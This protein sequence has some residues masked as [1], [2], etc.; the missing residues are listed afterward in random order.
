MVSD[1]VFWFCT[2][3]LLAWVASG[4]IWRHRIRKFRKKMKQVHQEILEEVRK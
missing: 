1:A 3:F 4:T 2:G